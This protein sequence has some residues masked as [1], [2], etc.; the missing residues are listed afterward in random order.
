LSRQAAEQFRT[1]RSRLYHLR[2][3]NAMRVILITSPIAGDGK[4][5]VASNLARA[6]VRQA[7]RRVLLVDADLRSARLHLPLG[8]AEEPGLSDY[9]AGAADE[10]AIIQHGEKGGLYFAPAGKAANNAS[11]LLSNG[12]WKSFIESTAP[13]FDWIIIDSPP[14]LPVADATVIASLCDGVLL[15]LRTGA[16]PTTA[17]EKACQELRKQNLIGVV[18]NGADEAALGSYGMHYG[19]SAGGQA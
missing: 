3:E 10:L 14:C 11:E 18:L 5:F 6:I 8:A 13:C 12:R 2:S 1:L 19:H 16:T 7:D 9:L 17:A 15:V 4:T